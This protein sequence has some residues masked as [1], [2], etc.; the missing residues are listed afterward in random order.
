[1]EDPSKKKHLPL[2]HYL[3]FSE[4]KNNTVQRLKTNHGD[5]DSFK[6]KNSYT[7]NLKH[8]SLKRQTDAQHPIIVSILGHISP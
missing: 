6:S 7:T 5:R 3:S 8:P 4:R 1:M 2:F